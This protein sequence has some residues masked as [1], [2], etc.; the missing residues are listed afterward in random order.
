MRI[1][2]REEFTKQFPNIVK[3]INE[4][5]E[6][7]FLTENENLRENIIFITLGGSYAYGTNIETSDTDVRGISL[8]TK[9]EILLGRDHE[10]TINED[11]IVGTN[12][13]SPA[14][15]TKKQNTINENI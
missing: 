10:Q 9:R 1:D 15:N 14:K 12:V 2:I 11:T 7:A 6:Y 13:T 4:S 8:N 3:Q 5:D